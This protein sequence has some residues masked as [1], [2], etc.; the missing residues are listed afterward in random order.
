M[1]IKIEQQPK[2]VVMAGLQAVIAEAEIITAVLLTKNRDPSVYG[3]VP[4]L[5]ADNRI[6]LSGSLEALYA[7]G[8]AP[9]RAAANA[10]RL[11]GERELTQAATTT[12]PITA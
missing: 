12:Q 9:E 7:V 4:L 1:Y 2:I 10:D 3:P 5:G 8:C 11:C 6:L